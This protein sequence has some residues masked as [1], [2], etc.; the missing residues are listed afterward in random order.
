ME[1]EKL[2]TWNNKHAVNLKKGLIHINCQLDHMHNTIGILKKIIIKQ[3]HSKDSLI[4][5]W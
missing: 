5:T 3:F 2:T 1:W 4:N